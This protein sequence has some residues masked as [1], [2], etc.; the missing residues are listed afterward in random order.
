VEGVRR[1]MM[2]N[3]CRNLKLSA[4]D[5]FRQN[6]GKYIVQVYF[7]ASIVTLSFL[8]MVF[9]AL[10]YSLGLSKLSSTYFWI[11][12][13]I[14][15][16]LSTIAS[17]FLFNLIALYKNL[18]NLLMDKTN[19]Q[20][21]LLYINH[22]LESNVLIQ[23]TIDHASNT[24][25]EKNSADFI[26]K[27]QRF[28]RVKKGLDLSFGY[29]LFVLIIVYILLFMFNFSKWFIYL[30]LVSPFF[31]YIYFIFLNRTIIALRKGKQLSIAMLDHTLKKVIEKQK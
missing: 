12:Y 8:C 29:Y 25:D 3:K 24:M 19:Y 15:L 23:R 16:V 9:L 26:K 10:F 11:S 1:G 20:F 5:D 31:L 21:Y 18:A 2:M 28:N 4:W 13:G 27:Y 30:L 17:Q 14:Y 7:K 22:D 6:I